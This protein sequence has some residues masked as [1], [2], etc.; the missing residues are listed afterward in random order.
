MERS[1]E[2]IFCIFGILKAGAIYVPMDPKLPQERIHYILEDTAA[3]LAITTAVYQEAFESKGC[4]T[5]VYEGIQEA[6][7]TII[8]T[9]V[10]RTISPEQLAYVIYT[11]GTTGKPKGVMIQYKS[12]QALLGRNESSLS[13][14]SYGSF[15]IE[16]DFYV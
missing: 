6:L 3:S 7:K 9:K 11:S 16:N 14:K 2:A 5:I 13:S 15:V 1:L 10:N 4:K 12:L 8:S